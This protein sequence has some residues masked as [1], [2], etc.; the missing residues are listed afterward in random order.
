[1]ILMMMLYSRVKRMWHVWRS[2]VEGIAAVEFAMVF[3]IMIMLLLGTVELG[4]GILANQKVI[5]SSQMVT[6]LLTRTEIVTD[7]QLAE[8]KRAGRLAL[9]PFD[10]DLVGFDIISIR[11]D[12]DSAD[13]DEEPDPVVVWR[14]TDNMDAI[15]DITERVLPLALDGDGLIVTYVRFPYEPPFAT[16]L[17]GNITMIE[18]T[19]SRG[20]K[21]PVVERE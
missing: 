8:A 5:S 1:M 17:V 4:N 14:N 13:A 18:A 9:A 12:P 6:D 20:R 10:P 21:S 19:F 11:Y 7:D 3:P 16:R 2:Q 15:P